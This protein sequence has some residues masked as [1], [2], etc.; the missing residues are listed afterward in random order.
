MG[1]RSADIGR[2]ELRPRCRS[3]RGC[4]G[5]GSGRTRLFRPL[6]PFVPDTFA[7]CEGKARGL[8]TWRF[9]WIGPPRWGFFWKV[10]GP[11]THGVAVGWPRTV[12]SGLKVI[13]LWMGARCAHVLRRKEGQTHSPSAS[14]FYWL[15]RS[16]VR[17]LGRRMCAPWTHVLRREKGQTHSLALRACIGCGVAALGQG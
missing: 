8:D 1:K 4:Q 16:R 13:G 7:A 3:G 6:V 15:R 5:R 11:L 10:L 14:C 17:V 2:C 12:P 9:E